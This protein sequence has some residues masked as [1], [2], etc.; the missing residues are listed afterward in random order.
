MPIMMILAMLL[1]EGPAMFAAVQKIRSL[2]SET[3]RNAFDKILAD[4]DAEVTAAAERLAA[5]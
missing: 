2:M 5:S 1:K 4:G 3:D